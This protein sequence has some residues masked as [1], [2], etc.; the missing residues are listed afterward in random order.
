ML[1]ARIALASAVLST[2]SLAN[3]VKDDQSEVAYQNTGTGN[4][5]VQITNTGNDT[6]NAVVRNADGNIV[7][8]ITLEPEDSKPVTA[9]QGGSIT[10]DDREY[11]GK[12]DNPEVKKDTNTSNA[13]YSVV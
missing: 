4:H 3:E 12:Q 2:L 8:W 9:P 1:P 7:G 6:I 10:V 5:T 11:S 13:K